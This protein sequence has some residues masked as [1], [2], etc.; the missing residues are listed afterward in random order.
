MVTR[1]G[2]ALHASW[3]RRRARQGRRCDLDMLALPDLSERA[4]AV[5]QAPALMLGPG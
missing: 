1:R 3:G 2:S 5:L 4:A